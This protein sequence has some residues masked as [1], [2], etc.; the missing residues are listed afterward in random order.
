VAHF[1]HYSADLPLHFIVPRL[2]LDFPSSRILSLITLPSCRERVVSSSPSC[3][4]PQPLFPLQEKPS[5]PGTPFSFFQSDSLLSLFVKP[6][7]SFEQDG[8]FLSHSTSSLDPDHFPPYSPRDTPP[9]FGR[10]HGWGLSCFFSLLSFSQ[11]DRFPLLSGEITV[12]QMFHPPPTE[13]TSPRPSCLRVCLFPSPF[14]RPHF[15]TVEF[16][17]PFV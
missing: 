7:P 17:S 2:F 3:V 9:P 13:M 1:S 11:H 8:F 6:I 15:H 12:L 4:Q 14:F 10:A 16:P 5:I